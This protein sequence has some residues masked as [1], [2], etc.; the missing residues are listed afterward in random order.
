MSFM[1]EALPRDS[2]HRHRREMAAAAELA[3][4]D[5]TSVH[6]RRQSAFPVRRGGP[7]NGSP[8][9]RRHHRVTRRVSA[10]WASLL[11][12]V[13]GGR[14]L[15]RSGHGRRRGAASVVCAVKRHWYPESAVSGRPLSWYGRRRG[16]ASVVCAVK[17]HWYPETGRRRRHM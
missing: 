11:R 17:R 15:S 10:R 12:Q 3:V 6:H 13:D 1:R 4:G 7:R 9:T 16:A 5:V 2:R 14:P 8:P